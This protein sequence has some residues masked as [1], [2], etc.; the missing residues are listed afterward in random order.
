MCVESKRYNILICLCLFYLL[1]FFRGLKKDDGR[2]KHFIRAGGQVV[3][4][5][6]RCTRTQINLDIL[7]L[8]PQDL[9]NHNHVCHASLSEDEPSFFFFFFF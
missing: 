6:L 8:A 7:S 9:V 3:V 2:C 1:T 4:E 5:M